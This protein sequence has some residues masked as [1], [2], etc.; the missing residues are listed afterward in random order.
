MV[1]AAAD[2]AAAAPGL[3]ICWRGLASGKPVRRRDKG[4]AG[5]PAGAVWALDGARHTSDNRQLAKRL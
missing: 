4:G 1:Q 2:M 5:K 3:R